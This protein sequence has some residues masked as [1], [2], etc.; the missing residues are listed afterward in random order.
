MRILA[1]IT[2]LILAAAGAMAQ[3]SAPPL[4]SPEIRQLSEAADQA[5]QRGELS[6]AWRH[7]VDAGNLLARQNTQPAMQRAADF[8]R[9][10][11]ELVSRE[12]TPKQWAVTQALLGNVLYDAGVRFKSVK[13]IEEA[14]VAYRA[15][16][17]EYSVERQPAEWAT[18]QN[19][20]GEA[21]SYLALRGQPDKYDEAMAAWRAAL[22]VYSKDKF[23]SE[24]IAIQQSIGFTYL[25]KAQLHDKGTDSLKAALTAFTA[26]LDVVSRDTDLPKWSETQLAIGEVQ[27]RLG[28]RL[29]DKD[30]FT[31]ALAAFEQARDG[32]AQA[33]DAARTGTLVAKIAEIKGKLAGK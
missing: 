5:V 21:F 11:L 29:A 25:V 3:E 2:F 26:T 15:A 19:R 10:A 9:G 32:F 16:L 4:D 1:A 7:R 24:W 20:L 33:G 27:R 6:L 31:A 28:D 22:T 18:L 8:Y 12:K 13:E 30:A 17:S 23:R 14:V